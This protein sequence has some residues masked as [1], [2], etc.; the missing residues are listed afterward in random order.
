MEGN[1]QINDIVY[2]CGV[3]RRLPEEEFQSCIYN[4]KLSF[5]HERYCNK[6]TLSSYMWHL[7]SVS[8]ESQT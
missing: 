6:T 1:C 3:T 4:H 2:K 8:T 5:K 7:K